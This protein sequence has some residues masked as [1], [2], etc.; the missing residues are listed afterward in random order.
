MLVGQITGPRQ[1]EMIELPVPEPEDDELVVKVEAGAICG[2]DLPFFLV[3]REDPV[4]QKTPLPLAPFYSMHELAGRVARS[5]CERFGEGDRVLALPYEHR[6]LAEYF[7]SHSAVA[8][9]IPE[10]PADRLVLAQPLGTII[11]ACLKLPNLLGQTAVVVGQGPIGQLFTALLRRMGILRLVAVDLLR[12]RLEVS[13]LMGATH[14]VCGGS[15]EV[16][17]AVRDL[18]GGPGADLAAAAAGPP[19]AGS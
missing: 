4:I 10:G 5:R 9:P 1:L 13:R 11:H 18:T 14:T 2:S 3:D 16:F 8:V 17:E 7:L 12:G 19:G 6:G 15:E